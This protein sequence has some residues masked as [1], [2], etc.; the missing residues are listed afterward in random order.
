ITL[1]RRRRKILSVFAKNGLG[2]LIRDSIV[3]KL[4]G[5]ER[6]SQTEGEHLRKVGVRLREAF[7][8]L[9]PTFIKLGQVLVTRQDLFPEEI[10]NELEKLLDKVPPMEFSKLEYIIEKE[11]PNG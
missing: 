2:L 1:G 4:M 11:L 8:E 7:E 3:R 5:K 6:R 10:T 9:G